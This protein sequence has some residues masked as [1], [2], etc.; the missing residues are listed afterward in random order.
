[1]IEVVSIG[2]VLVDVVA[3]P[4][5]VGV[6]AA[7]DLNGDVVLGSVAGPIVVQQASRA[8]AA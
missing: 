6:R 1:V 7:P 8:D 4:S 2:A 3:L 5:R